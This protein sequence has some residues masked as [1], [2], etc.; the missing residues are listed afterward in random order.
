[1]EDNILTCTCGAIIKKSSK[2]AHL[3]SKKHLDSISKK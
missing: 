3:K 2:S 1:M